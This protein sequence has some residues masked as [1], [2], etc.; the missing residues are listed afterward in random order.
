M[1][2]LVLCLICL[3]AGMISGRGPS[4]PVAGMRALP[5][6][7]APDRP[8]AMPAWFHRDPAVQ[9]V[10][11]ELSWR[12]TG[13]ADWELRR[14]AETVVA[15]AARHG[16]DPSLVLAVIQ[17]ES[18]GYN[19]A[20]SPVGAMGLMQMMPYTAEELC[21]RLGIPWRGPDSLFDPVLNVTLGA[22]YLKELSDRYGRWDMALAAYNWGPAH[23]DRRIRRGVRLPQLYV[24]QV[25][26]IYESDDRPAR[27]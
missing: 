16:I 22:A 18:G 3:A 5:A 9:V 13:L 8:V 21:A 7:S 6:V 23:I 10:L 11:D 1:R 19:F 26:R 2:R 20:V 15:E 17:V 14:V 24:E 27:S 25:M 12:H 4:L